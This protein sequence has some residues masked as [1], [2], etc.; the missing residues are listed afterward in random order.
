MLV[1]HGA[2][3]TF[4]SATGPA[5][6]DYGTINGNASRADSDQSGM[7]DAWKEETYLSNRHDLHLAKEK[8][9]Q[10]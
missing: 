6:N 7:P 4:P 10:S 1:A 2:P 5:N 3:P 9:V 8:G